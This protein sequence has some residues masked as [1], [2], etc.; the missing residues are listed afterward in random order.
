MVCS[1]RELPDTGT[2]DGPKTKNSFSPRIEI[3]RETRKECSPKTQFLSFVARDKSLMSVTRDHLR[4]TVSQFFVMLSG[5]VSKIVE[6][7]F[8]VVRALPGISH[9]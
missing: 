9:P 2:Q 7:A 1:L 3:L 5:C 4:E 6:D 8:C